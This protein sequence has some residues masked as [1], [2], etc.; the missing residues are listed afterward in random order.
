MEALVKL[1]TKG[2]EAVD[3][4]LGI[5][6]L[7]DTENPT[8]SL[9][10]ISE[11]TGHVKSTALRLL[12]SLQN[13]G[14]VVPTSD[15]RYTV[16]AQAFR[17]GC[18]YQH[19]FRLDRI[20]RPA[21]RKLVV[22]TGES[23]SFFRREGNKR[24]CLFREDSHQ[25]L[26]EHVAEGEAVSLDKG[27][28]GHVLTSFETIDGGHPGNPAALSSLP[29]IA[30]G[31]RGPDIAGMSAPIFAAGSGLIGALSLSG[32]RIRFTTEKIEEMKPVF[33]KAAADLSFELGSRFYE[34]GEGY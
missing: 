18:V 10:D 7:F 15:K 17:I 12:V 16:G 1:K 21:L 4:A 23:G 26:R 2:V 13:A 19:T 24:V 30:L 25:V 5:L 14:L 31:E 29:I 11:R 8:L 20:V 27:A 33:L 28:A 32:P 22:A 34:Q 9:G 3:K 6:M